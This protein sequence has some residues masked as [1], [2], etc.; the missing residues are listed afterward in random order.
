[1]TDQKHRVAAVKARLCPELDEPYFTVEQK[2]LSV[3]TK[4][5]THKNEGV[6]LDKIDRR[7]Y[8]RKCGKQIDPFEAL[9]YHAASEQRLVS[10]R[11]AIQE[12]ETRER[13]R[14][15]QEKARRPFLRTVTGR[16]AI[17]D[18]TLKAEPIIGYKHR[19]A[20]GHVVETRGATFWK[21]RTCYEC[22]ERSQTNRKT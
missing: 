12:A 22:R 13:V 2:Y 3:A 16:T 14:K 8:C 7:V 1:M 5:C 17:H 4:R 10:T 15:E 18:L 20:C 9:L 6:R 11:Q 21:T 19:L